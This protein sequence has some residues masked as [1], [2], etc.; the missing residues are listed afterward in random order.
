[1]FKPFAA[2]GVYIMVD[3]QYG[4]TGKGLLASYIAHNWGDLIDGGYLTNNG[5]NSGHTF[6]YMG[7]RHVVKQLP[8]SAVYRS[9]EGH[10]GVKA[11]LTNGAII[12][13]DQLDLEVSRYPG[14]EVETG[15]HAVIVTAEDKQADKATVDSV[16]STGQGVGPALARKLQR[17]NVDVAQNK[18]SGFT[19][20][21]WRQFRFFYEVPQGFSLGLNSGFYPYVTSRECTVGQALADAALPATA[22]RGVFM[23]VRTLPIRVGNTDNAS[24]GPCYHDQHELDWEGLPFKPEYTT[25]T[26]RQRRIFSWSD[27][28]FMDAVAAND[29]RVVF[30][31]FVNY[32][33]VMGVDV[34]LWLRQHILL[35]YTR[36]VGQ[37]PDRVWLG[38]GPKVEDVETWKY[39]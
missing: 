15:P 22:V 38:R 7:S 24:S 12:D 37:P 3:G 21:N 6:Y 25:V 11:L 18:Q 19:G 13:A 39:E 9:L 5:P 26:N 14:V 17:Q 31:N 28:Q 34:D 1:M 8:V 23:S 32:L 4:S 33:E 30:V 29:P 27:Q 2:R 16:A 36:V 10:L 20:H 35:P